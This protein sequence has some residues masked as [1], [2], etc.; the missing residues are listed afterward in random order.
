MALQN[1][2]TLRCN[3][4]TIMPA[5]CDSRIY[6]KSLCTSLVYNTKKPKLWCWCGPSFK[7]DNVLQISATWTSNDRTIV[8]CELSYAFPIVQH[9]QLMFVLM[10]VFWQQGKTRSRIPLERLLYHLRLIWKQLASTFYA[11]GKKYYRTTTDASDLGWRYEWAAGSSKEFWNTK[12][13]L[14]HAG[15][16]EICEDGYRGSSGIIYGGMDWF[17]P[18]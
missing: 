13:Y 5:D 16:G 17:T 8:D 10:V 6:Y 2:A 11:G 12:I 7:N 15:D 3:A 4:K 14:S 18:K 1:T 9:R